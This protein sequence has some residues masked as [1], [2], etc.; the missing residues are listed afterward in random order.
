MHALKIS[1]DF[2]TQNNIQ[3]YS[4]CQ[5]TK[6]IILVVISAEMKHRSEKLK[7]NFKSGL[8]EI[9]LLLIA[10]VESTTTFRT[11]F[12][13]TLNPGFCIRHRKQ[14]AFP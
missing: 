10:L 6:I 3:K 9:P 4:N 2:G 1:A 8:R 13:Y 7:V 12:N 5:E 14:R 11:K